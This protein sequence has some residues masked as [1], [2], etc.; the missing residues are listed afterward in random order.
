[1][2]QHLAEHLKV[3]A[4]EQLEAALLDAVVPQPH[5]RV[6]EFGVDALDVFHGQLL[7]QHALVEGQGEARVDKAAVI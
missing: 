5:Q 4:E 6:V 3:D 1:M 2:V 7:V